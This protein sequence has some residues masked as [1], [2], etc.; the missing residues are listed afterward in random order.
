MF[1]EQARHQYLESEK[2]KKSAPRENGG[3]RF[4]EPGMEEVWSFGEEDEQD[5]SDSTLI[6]N[7]E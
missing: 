5:Y 1:E 6:E 7:E 3:G 4:S 2:S